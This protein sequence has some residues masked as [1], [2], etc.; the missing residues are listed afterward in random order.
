[1][2]RTQKMHS[3]RVNPGDVQKVCALDSIQLIYI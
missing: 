1:M 3:V 2:L